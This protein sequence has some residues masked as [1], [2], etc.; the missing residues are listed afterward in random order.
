MLSKFLLEKPFLLN[1]TDTPSTTASNN[2]T[3]IVIKEKVDLAL[4][5]GVEC[6]KVPL[7]L[8]SLD[9]GSGSGA[10]SAKTISPTATAMAVEEGGAVAIE[11][12]AKLQIANSKNI[13]TGNGG[14]NQNQVLVCVGNSTTICLW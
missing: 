12:F 2:R 11:G 4:Y 13:D 6:A 8:V 1:Q 5:N 14:V 7:R 3:K 10:R 9:D